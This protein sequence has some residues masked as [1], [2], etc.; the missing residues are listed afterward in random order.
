MAEYDVI[1]IGGGPGLRGRDSRRQLGQKTAVVEREAPAAL[2]LNY[3]CIPAKTV[4][5]TADLLHRHRG[6]CRSGHQVERCLDR[7]AGASGS[8]QG[9]CD[10]E[11][12]VEFL[13]NKNKVERLSTARHP[14]RR[15]Q[16][17]GRRR[18]ASGEGDHPRYRLGCL[19]DSGIDFSTA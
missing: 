4:L 11:E 7:L 18:R 5:H 3:A 6:G 12:G 2:R 1:V 15:R 10:L 19:T 14:R 13:W 16:G 8:R 9:V 17:E